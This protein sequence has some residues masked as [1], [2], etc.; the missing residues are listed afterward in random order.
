GEDRAHVLPGTCFCTKSE[1]GKGCGKVG[2]KAC[3]K[4]RSQQFKDFASEEQVDPTVKRRE[5]AP[6]VGHTSHLIEGE[7]LGHQQPN[8]KRKIYKNGPDFLSQVIFNGI[9]CKSPIPYNSGNFP[10]LPKLQYNQEIERTATQNLS[11]IAHVEEE[12]ANMV[13]E[14]IIESQRQLIEI[15][16]NKLRGEISE[17]EEDNGSITLMKD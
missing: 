15:D 8:R 10:K 1:V 4:V 12:M 17:K 7:S 2:S 13:R 11:Q 5:R 9:S 14:S 3:G 6:H 16:H